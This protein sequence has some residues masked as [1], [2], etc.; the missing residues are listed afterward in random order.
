MLT[1]WIS[2]LYVHDEGSVEQ[3]S[4]IIYYMKADSDVI[5]NE[6]LS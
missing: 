2:R 3:G 1:K 6:D 5:V 4:K